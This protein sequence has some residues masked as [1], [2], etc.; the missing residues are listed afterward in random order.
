MPRSFLAISIP[1]NIKNIICDQ[2]VVP[3]YKHYA[4]KLIKWTKKENLHITL[5]FLGN[6][7]DQ[8]YQQLN[9]KIQ[10]NMSLFNSFTINL[11]TF[12][13]FPSEK[14]FHAIILKPQPLTPIQN[15]ANFLKKAAETCEI[16]TDNRSF[17]PHLTLGKVN[18]KD[19]I[20]FETFVKTKTSAMH[21]EVTEIKLFESV[22][23]S[24]GSIYTPIATYKLGES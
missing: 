14:K 7:T 3:L 21:F 4:T 5:V 15:L 1:D 9:K 20:D 19:K 10:E 2:V 16:K 11:T 24:S 22:L 8:Q 18:D 13:A 23:D 6:I 17:K 12:E